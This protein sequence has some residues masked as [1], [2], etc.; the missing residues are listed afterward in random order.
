MEAATIVRGVR[1][2]K[3]LLL[4]PGS[5]WRKRPARSDYGRERDIA[6]YQAEFPESG[7][8]FSEFL[9]QCRLPR[10]PREGKPIGVVVMPWV[11]TPMPWYQIVL[12]LGLLQRGQPVVLIWDDSPFPAES[13]YLTLQNDWICA[14]L[15]YLRKRGLRVVRL[16]QY[17][18]DVLRSEDH[19][20]IE[21][22]A[23]SNVVWR[24]RARQ[25]TDADLRMGREGQACLTRT[26]PLIRSMLRA[27]EFD[28]LL[29]P[30]GVYGTSGLFLL[31]GRQ[32][33]LR[34]ATVDCDFGVAQICTDGIAA[35]C[36]DIP[37]SFAGIWGAP[38]PVRAEAI[39]VARAEL[40]LR[41]EARDRGG[42]QAIG[43]DRRPGGGEEVLIPLNIEWDTAALGRH[44][45]FA[46]T[47][48]WI[49]ST[50]IHLLEHSSQRV[51]IRLHPHE[52][53][54]LQHSAFNIQAIVRDVVGEH[55]RVRFIAADDP[56][57]TYDLLHTARVVLPFVSTI[58]IE[59]AALGK[60]VLISGASYY[61]DLGFVW[62]ARSREQYFDL[63][64]QALRGELPLKPDQA[65]RA[66]ICFY[67]TAVSN[68]VWTEFTPH[69][70]D[71]WRWCQRSPDD[72]LQDQTV[73][74]ILTSIDQNIPLALVRH[75]WRTKQ[76]DTR[77]SE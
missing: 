17:R 33:G 38:D 64:R 29:V 12:A 56:V 62:S 21:K 23:K 66:W 48:D 59:A 55:P 43:S 10:T 37:R 24:A 5:L 67:L 16:S 69:P 36:A 39:E 20:H 75:W 50:V 44:D 35:H 14:S 73:Q 34:V 6:N 65:E 51:A 61:A 60:T 18:P 46:D 57:N 31:A 54:P 28:A 45:I 1:K 53:R 26:L 47:A 49:T 27:L 74:H 15:R 77:G 2:V 32:V 72:L 25:P 71:F 7:Q 40:K 3:R 9:R 52:R 22:L 42:F 4:G 19:Q 8:L 68:R 58:G 11:G 41:M 76:S 63:L 13:D 30:G 70:S